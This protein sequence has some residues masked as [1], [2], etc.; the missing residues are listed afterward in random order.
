MRTHKYVDFVHARENKDKDCTELKTQDIEI[1]SA[2]I[3][4]LWSIV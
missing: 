1:V 2:K 3:Q 4:D